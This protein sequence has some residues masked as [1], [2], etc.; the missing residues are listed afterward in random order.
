VTYPA[1][2]DRSVWSLRRSHSDPLAFL[3]GLADAREDIVPFALAGKPAFLVKHPDAVE[4]VLITEHHRFAKS[5]GLQRARRLL[6]NG[7]LTADGESHRRQRAIVQPAFH[8]QQLERYGSIMARHGARVR[9]RWRDRQLVDISTEAGDLTLA[10]V[11]E[12]MFGCDVASLTAEVRRA[13]RTASET[14]DPLVSLLAPARRVRPERAR[15]ARIV[16]DLVARAEGDANLVSLLLDG[17]PGGRDRITDQV[18][19]DLLTILLAGHDTIAHALVWTWVA[20]ANEPAIRAAI[21]DEVDAVL[22]D[23]IAGAS[24]VPALGLT[25]RVLSESLRL[26]PP[27]W[28]IARSAMRDCCLSGVPIPAGAVVLISPY[29]MHR[30]PRFFPNP[31]SFDP[32]RWLDPAARPKLAFIP[33]GA[34]PRACVGEG[35]AWMEGVL[36]IATIAQRWR[37]EPAPGGD[38]IR[39]R[40]QITLRPPRCLQMTVRHRSPRHHGSNVHL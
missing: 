21:E 36:L 35:F 17:Q 11:V 16:D 1:G 29:L 5:Y 20:L 38:P 26:S 22:D 7:L 10:I 14:L 24:D 18:R 31:T 9:D 15:L 32:D 19:D 28:V 34:G 33:F 8:R 39:P 25:R 12:A 37:L 23:R 13:V 3:T 27:A 30:D 40:P 2:F 6:G 4:S